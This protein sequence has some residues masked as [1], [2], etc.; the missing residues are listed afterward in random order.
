MKSNMVTEI[1]NVNCDRF[2][3]HEIESTF[4]V[5][6][7]NDGIGHYE[8]WGAKCYDAGCD[9]IVLDDIFNVFLVRR[10]Q[11]K[12]K[13]SIPKCSGVTYNEIID[14]TSGKIIGYHWKHVRIIKE[15]DEILEEIDYLL[16]NSKISDYF[17]CYE[18]EY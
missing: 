18:P 16:E 5:M 12:D 14:I 11:V 15:N 7:E 2:G 1:I 17:D 8:F 9:F 13:E 10:G 4:S 6:I 3:E